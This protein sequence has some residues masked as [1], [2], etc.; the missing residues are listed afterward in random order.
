MTLVTGLAAAY[1]LA[2]EASVATMEIVPAAP[3]RYRVFPEMVPTASLFP[4]KVIVPLSV[5][6]A[7][8]VREEV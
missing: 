5:A 8:R 1:P 7:L 4:E 6:D 2:G 3:L